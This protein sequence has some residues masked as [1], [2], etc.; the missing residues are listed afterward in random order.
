MQELSQQLQARDSA[1]TAAEQRLRRLERMTGHHAASVSGSSSVSGSGAPS[2][3]RMAATRGDLNGAAVGAAAAQHQQQAQL[4]ALQEQ[5]EARSREVH[6]LRELLD[7]QQQQQQRAGTPASLV[8]QPSGASSWRPSS[9][10]GARATPA[11]SPGP[12]RCL[13]ADLDKSLEALAAKSAEVAELRRQ[14]RAVGERHQAELATAEAAAARRLALQQ[15]L[16]EAAQMEV[17]IRNQVGAG[18]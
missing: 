12:L 10:G 13:P 2:E 11:P 18:Y 5:L 8:C 16:L 4:A 14:L 7:Q 3:E 15:R 6:S 17:D 9:S 1:L